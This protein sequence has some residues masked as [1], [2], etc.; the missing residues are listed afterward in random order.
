MSDGG[1]VIIDM[2]QT[3]SPSEQEGGV[4]S[5]AEA[6]KPL[7]GRMSTHAGTGLRYNS[8]HE[9]SAKCANRAA[10]GYNSGMGEIF[11]KVANVS[12]I[13]ANLRR[14][15]ADAAP[16]GD[17]ACLASEVSSGCASKGRNAMDEN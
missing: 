17:A 8:E 14:T 10:Q 2:V 6:R 13:A 16:A 7:P 11:R 5:L 3:V 1:Y 4:G 9:F 15:L 12:P